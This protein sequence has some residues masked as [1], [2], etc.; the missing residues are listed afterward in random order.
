MLELLGDVGLLRN[1]KKWCNVL[2]LWYRMVD[3]TRAPSVTQLG[4]STRHGDDINT[5]DEVILLTK[6]LHD[7]IDPRDGR[8]VDEGRA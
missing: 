7:L 3:V 1:V 4:S 2:V 8:S 5:K 6:T